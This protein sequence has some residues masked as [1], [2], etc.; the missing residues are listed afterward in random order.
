M[1]KPL[2]RLLVFWC[3]CPKK[4]NYEKQKRKTD[5]K[6]PLAMQGEAEV[7]WDKSLETPAFPLRK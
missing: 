4:Q 2:Y 3:E 7:P 1:G 6:L 5:N